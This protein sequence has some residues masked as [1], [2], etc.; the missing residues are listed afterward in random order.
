[1]WKEARGEAAGEG[2]EVKAD[3]RETS[4]VYEEEE[5]ESK[6]NMELVG[7]QLVQRSNA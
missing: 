3:M 4:A 1:M 2:D 6:G 5:V 7:P